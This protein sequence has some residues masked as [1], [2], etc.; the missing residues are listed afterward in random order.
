MNTLNN[1][2][3][4]GFLRLNQIIGRKELSR[5]GKPTVPAIPAIIPVSKTEWWRGVKSGKFP[6]PYKLSANTTVWHV[7]DIRDLI[8]RIITPNSVDPRN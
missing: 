8:I 7:Q 4:D 5:E 1:M 3:P 2:P 6:K